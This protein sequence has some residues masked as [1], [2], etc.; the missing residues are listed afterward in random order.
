LGGTV[1]AQHRDRRERRRRR[2]LDAVADVEYVGCGDG[3]LT[4]RLDHPR[5]AD[6]LL[7]GRGQQQVKLVPKT[8]KAARERGL[9]MS[10]NVV[11]AYREI[12]GVG[13]PDD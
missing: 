9:R 6:Q 7:A 5:P 2:L 1:L 10:K 12:G 11:V 8:T 13:G 4:A 3:D